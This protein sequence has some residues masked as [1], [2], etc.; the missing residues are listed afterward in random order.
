MERE[1]WRDEEREKEK[2]RREG[3]MEEGK[4]GEGW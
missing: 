4:G 1:E 3:M 2:K